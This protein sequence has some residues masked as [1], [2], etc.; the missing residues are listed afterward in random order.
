MLMPTVTTLVMAMAGVWRDECPLWNLRRIDVG[1]K[2]GAWGCMGVRVR[3]R[4]GGRV[5]RGRRGGIIWRGGYDIDADK[6]GGWKV[7]N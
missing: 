2:M 7:V 6:K 5:V 4:M 3:V 1:M